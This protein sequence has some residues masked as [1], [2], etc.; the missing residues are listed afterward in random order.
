MTELRAR[1]VRVLLTR[2]RDDIAGGCWA[3]R[4]KRAEKRAESDRVP[5]LNYATNPLEC[6][7]SD[8]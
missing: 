1:R 6:H 7:L 5:Y 8:V 4:E 3:E 2:D